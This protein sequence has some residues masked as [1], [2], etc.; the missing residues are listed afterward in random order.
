MIATDRTHLVA[1]CGIDCGNSALYLSR[2]DEATMTRLLARGIPAEKL[3]C[4]GCRDVKGNCPV[5]GETCATYLCAVEKGVRY[6]FEC[7]E[8]P[9]AKLN[10]AADRAEILPHN[11]KVFNLCAIQRLG[12]DGFVAQSAEIEKTYFKGKMVI[13]RGPQLRD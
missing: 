3:P 8:F 9:C 13:G 12:V 10:P 6:C 5:I 11:L 4:P 1:Y 7:A 2:Y